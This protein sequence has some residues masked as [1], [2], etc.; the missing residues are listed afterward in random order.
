MNLKLFCDIG[1]AIYGKEWHQLLAKDLDL[2]HGHVRN[3]AAGTAAL[4]D[5]VV[6]EVRRVLR[7]RIARL[8]MLAE[9]LDDDAAPAV[10]ESKT[11]LT[12]A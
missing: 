8:G 7:N 12:G 6:M 1:E 10:R 3:M 2:S 5:I 4:E 9:R 11:A